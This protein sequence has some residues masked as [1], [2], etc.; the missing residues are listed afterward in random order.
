MDFL[1]SVPEYKVVMFGDS[2][3]GKTSLIEQFSTGSASPETQPTVGAAYTRCAC[4][5]PYGTVVLSIWDTAGQERYRSLVPLY[6]R[7]ADGAVVVIDLSQPHPCQTLDAIWTSVEGEAP[8]AIRMILAANKVDLVADDYDYAE[9]EKWAAAHDVAWVKTSAKTGDGVREVFEALADS[10]CP[11]EIRAKFSANL[12]ATE[13]QG[14]EPKQA[15]GC[16]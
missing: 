3:V 2:G 8:I 6:F 13:P 14:P 16:C 12:K 7:S 9:V 11:A 10:L 5:L 4:D 15:D 1:P